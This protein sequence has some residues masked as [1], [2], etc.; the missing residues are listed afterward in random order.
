MGKRSNFERVERDYYP[1]PYEAVIPLLPHLTEKTFAEPC[2][3]DGQLVKHLEANR[4]RCRWMS[5]IE[6]QAEGIHKADA[7]SLT[8]VLKQA[9]VIITN[10]PWDRTKKSGYLLHRFIEHFRQF[11]P[12]WLLLDADYKYTKQSSPYMKYCSKVVAVGRVKWI[13]GSKMT[14]KDNAAW[15]RF[16]KEECETKFYGR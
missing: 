14:G 16:E 10:T 4:L 13:P 9:P 2:A 6:P 15:Y 8:T 1:T 5:D 11:A 12:C 3:G 7:F